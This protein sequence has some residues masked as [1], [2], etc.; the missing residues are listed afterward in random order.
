MIEWQIQLI[1]L[2][3]KI[4]P[5]PIELDTAAITKTKKKRTK[6]NTKEHT[7]Q[8]RRTLANFATPKWKYSPQWLPMFLRIKNTNKQNQECNNHAKPLSWRSTNI[9]I[10]N[11]VKPLQPNAT[12]K[13]NANPSTH[14]TSPP[15]HPILLNG[16]TPGSNINDTKDH[17]NQCRWMHFNFAAVP[18]KWLRPTAAKDI[19]PPLYANLM[20]LP[21]TPDSTALCNPT[22]RYPTTW[23]IAGDLELKYP[24]LTCMP[25]SNYPKQPN[26][27]S[28]KLTIRPK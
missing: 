17:P 6:T 15:T 18:Q 9:T 26:S 27:P 16:Y 24:C 11:T 3:T 22:E 4:K 28:L 5:P 14:E 2:H 25:L 10:S 19:V 20:C 13:T 8:K 21:P 7:N 1:T 23:F 12:P